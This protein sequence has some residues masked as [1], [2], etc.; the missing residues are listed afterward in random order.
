MLLIKFNI[1]QVCRECNHKIRQNLLRHSSL[2]TVFYCVRLFFLKLM[3]DV[4]KKY[5]C[6][7][8]RKK[9]ERSGSYDILNFVTTENKQ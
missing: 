1:S 8:C 3:T 6:L 7:F 4:L 2:K 9:I 5:C